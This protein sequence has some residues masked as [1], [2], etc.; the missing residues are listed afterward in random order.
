MIASKGVHPVLLVLGALGEDAFID[1]RDA[2]N[3]PE[4]VNHLFG[5]R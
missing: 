4:E 3:L 5:A 2:N 1:S